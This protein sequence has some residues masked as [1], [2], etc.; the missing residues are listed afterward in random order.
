MLQ[1]QVE[2]GPVEDVAEVLLR[3]L[4][5]HPSQLFAEFEPE[6]RAAAS[7]AQVPFNHTSSFAPLYLLVFNHTPAVQ[8]YSCL[9]LL[10]KAL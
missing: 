10:A 4:G 3:E 5:A 1:D 8:H 2:A 7:L 9:P 6:A